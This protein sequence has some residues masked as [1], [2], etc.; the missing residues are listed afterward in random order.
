MNIKSLIVVI[1]L[2][3]S[4]ITFAQQK[5][6]IYPITT[7]YPF[8]LVRDMSFVDLNNGYLAAVK[9]VF[10]GGNYTGDVNYVFKT[11]NSGSNWTKVWEYTYDVNSKKPTVSFINANTGYIS[12]RTELKKTTNGGQNWTNINTSGL[13]NINDNLICTRSNGDLFLLQVDASTIFKYSISTGTFQL[14]KN[15]GSGYSI[16][17]FEISKLNDNNIYVCG[18][19]Y[20]NLTYNPFFAKSTDAGLNWEIKIDGDDPN[21][22]G[23]LEHMSVTNDGFNDVVKLGGISK[24]I[25]FKNNQVN[26]LNNYWGTGRRI[27]FG[28][29]NNG[30][31]LSYDGA[32]D[33]PPQSTGI[34]NAYKT[35]DGGQTWVSD[36]EINSAG[37]FLNSS[38]RFFSKG[39]IVYLTESIDGAIG[40]FRVRNLNENILTYYN[41]ISNPGSFK[42]NNVSNSTPD[43]KYIRGGIYPLWT[44][45]ILNQGQTEEKIFYKWSF[46]SMPNSV[47]SYNMFYEGELSTHYK[48]KQKSTDETAISNAGQTK[49]IRDDLGQI[50][51]VHSSVGGIF[52]SRSPGSGYPFETETVVNGGQLYSQ[53]FPNDNTADKNKNPSVNEIK[54][55]N[56][57]N[58]APAAYGLAAVWERYNQQTNKIDV[59]CAL[60][61]SDLNNPWTRFGNNLNA[62]DGKIT[63]FNASVNDN[64]KPDVYSLYIPIIPG[65]ESDVS[66][67]MMIVPHLEPTPNGNRLVVS[68]RYKDFGGFDYVDLGNNPTRDFIIVNDYITDYSVAYKPYEDV[69]INSKGAYVYLTYKKNGNVYYRRELIHF[70]SYYNQIIRDE[71]PAAEQELNISAL[72]NQLLRNTP[73]I[74]L[75]N[76]MPTITYQ[77]RNTVYRA[78]NIE[79]QTGIQNIQ[80]NYY[81]IYVYMRDANNVWS[82]YYYNSNGFQTQENPDI[83]GSTNYNAFLVNFSKANNTFYQ[84]VKINGS[85]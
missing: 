37:H 77:G 47:P 49:A 48:T 70:S 56:Q 50:H 23:F 53:Q 31:Y 18:Y 59:L 68:A 15:F 72:D 7:Q 66:N 76:G 75:R 1:M 4:S 71:I 69:N 74:T 34:A 17:H 60:R 62:L 22:I 2:I 63:S 8:S 36:L 61:S 43:T 46:N 13:S 26:I 9:L 3:L 25:E 16:K 38:Y 83:E 57:E 11:T 78:I 64:S 81:P 19:R 51:Q 5:Y 20:K 73:D 41:N 6:E 32:T 55:F 14:I 44:E 28:D 79:G 35:T 85:N 67:F 65:G 39:N 54:Y 12:K 33:D 21:N 58:S 27:S 42:I 45:P 84:F 30:Y 24:L 52:Y 10:N 40:Y 80:L 29:A 82:S